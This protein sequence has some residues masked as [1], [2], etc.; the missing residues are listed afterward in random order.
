MGNTVLNN[1]FQQDLPCIGR[2]G[3][4]RYGI[5][6]V[7]YFYGMVFKIPYWKYHTVSVQYGIQIFGMVFCQK[8]FFK[9]PYRNVQYGIFKIQYGII[10]NTLNWI[11]YRTNTV[12]Y[13]SK[14]MK[15]MKIPYWKVRYGISNYFFLHEPNR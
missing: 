1:L 11:P 2:V 12:W 8:S 3:G 13:F 15:I 6:S 4:A 10:K 9:I 5:L 7:W 14:M